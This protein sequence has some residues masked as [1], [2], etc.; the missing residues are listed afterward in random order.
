LWHDPDLALALRWRDTNRPNAVWAQHYDPGFDVAMSFIDD[1][2]TSNEAE[3]AERERKRRRDVRRTRIFASIL[4]V[5]FLMSLGFAIFAFDARTKAYASRNEAVKQ[6]NEAEIARK[7]AVEER[8]KAEVAKGEA[9][10][11]AERAS[12]E[13]QKAKK[14]AEI[15]DHERDAAEAAR[16]A[17]EAATERAHEQQLV[18]EQATK[19]AERAATEA[20][21]TA[22]GFRQSYLGDKNN[23]IT[24]SGRLA[25]L[26]SPEEAAV[27]RNYYA[28]AMAEIGRPDLSKDESAR[29]LETFPDNIGALTN[30]GYMSLIN[31]QPVQALR[32]FERVRQLDPQYSLNYL[33]LG[34]TQANLKDYSGASNSIQKAIE[35]YRPGYFDGV[36]DSEVSEDIR[37]STGRHVIYAN[38][39]EF[40]AALYYELAGIEAFRGGKNFEERLNEADQHA[41]R[42]NSLVEGYLTALNWAWLQQRKEPNDYGSWVIQAHLWRRAGY[43]D[44]SRYYYEK[45]QCQHE[46]VNDPRYAGLADFVKRQLRILPKSRADISCNKPPFVNR[47]AR[48]AIF[49]ANEWA[50]IGHYDDALNLLDPEVE[51][52]PN[53]IELLLSRARY[54]QSAGYWAGRFG[55]EE[56]QKNYYSLTR[57]DFEKLLKLSEE[58]PAYKPIVYLWW[59]DIGPRIGAVSDEQK[60]FYAQQVINLGP[61]NS[62]ALVELSRATADNDPAKA[63]D[64]MKRSIA[65][66]PSAYSYYELAVLQNRIRDYHGALQSMK[67]AIALQSDNADF[68][69]ERR[70][71]EEGVGVSEAERQLHLAEGYCEIGDVYLRKLRAASAPADKEKAFHAADDAYR[72]SF[73]ILTQL[74][75]NE[76]VLTDLSMVNAKLSRLQ[77]LNPKRP[78]N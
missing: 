34:V 60:R 33:N 13:E 29:V 25:E 37:Q 2:K 71:A 28:T 31:F 75:R 9:Q 12:E 16:D 8:K 7:E 21:R 77:D 1:S 59:S 69:E 35:W 24:L 70:R 61:A 44:W 4:G 14:A 76:K 3:I 20:L 10:H 18:A 49:E 30:R 40:N 32:D 72:K 38:G 63:I 22:M 67:F 46:K 26:T 15:A 68:Y 50:Q 64:Y 57:Q 41:S 52:D 56:S 43:D 11:S 27:W 53:N 47:D 36:F 19:R 5:A 66:D 23:I 73:D 51:K 65:L 74:T 62:N 78:E 48:T 58:N 55:R 45:F 6:R 39:N 54:R 42:M 17:A